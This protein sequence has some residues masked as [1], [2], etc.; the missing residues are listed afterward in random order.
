MLFEPLSVDEVEALVNFAIDEL[1]VSED[2][3][4]ALFEL[5]QATQAKTAVAA[6]GDHIR[7]RFPDLFSPE[8]FQRQASEDIDYL[9]A[10]SDSFAS[11]HEGQV[12]WTG[13]PIHTLHIR[14]ADRIRQ[15]ISGDMWKLPDWLT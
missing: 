7:D 5:F 13:S 6:Y 12:H 15:I 9:K 11:N 8:P 14:I 10:I 1:I 2:A 4:P 3:G